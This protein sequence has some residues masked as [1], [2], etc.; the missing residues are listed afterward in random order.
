MNLTKS[1]R[2][3]GYKLLVDYN[4]NLT[5]E[6]TCSFTDGSVVDRHSS[7]EWWEGDTLITNETG[8]NGTW[9]SREIIKSDSCGVTLRIQNFSVFD[10]GR[11]L[12]KCGVGNYDDGIQFD[13]EQWYDRS[14]HKESCESLQNPVVDILPLG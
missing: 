8:T 13:L 10:Y 5:V 4:S 2:D 3:T 11:F 14:E 12:C 9:W 6:L 7:L 1:K